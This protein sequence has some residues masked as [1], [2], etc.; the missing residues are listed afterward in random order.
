MIFS[1][2][3]RKGFS[4]INDHRPTAIKETRKP[5]DRD[6]HVKFSPL[7]LREPLSLIPNLLVSLAV[8]FNAL[9]LLRANG[10]AGELTPP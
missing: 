8:V 7:R 1:T 6:Y 5:F 3:R 4:P 9:R 10:T 2:R